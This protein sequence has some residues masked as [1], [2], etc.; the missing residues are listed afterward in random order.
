MVDIQ[1]SNTESESEMKTRA[2]KLILDRIC[3]KYLEG[4]GSSFSQ[5]EIKEL[6]RGLGPGYIELNIRDLFRG[7]GLISMDRQRWICMRC[8]DETDDARLDGKWMK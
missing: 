2:M 7:S 6:L 5:D 3:R 8:F 4:N 1:P